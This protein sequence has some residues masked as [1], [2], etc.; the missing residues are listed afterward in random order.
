MKL[1][2]KNI[3][4][5]LL[6]AVAWISCNDDDNVKVGKQTVNPVRVKEIEGHNESWG[7][8]TLKLE[9]KNDKISTIER[10]DKNGRQKGELEITKEQGVMTY[11]LDDYVYKIDA[12]A[13]ADLDR[14]LALKYGVGNYSLEDSIPLVAKTVYEVALTFDEESMVTRQKISYFTP[15]KDFGV[16]ED[17]DNNYPLERVETYIYEYDEGGNVLNV[18]L[19]IDKYRPENAKDYVSRELYKYEYEYHGGKIVTNRIYRVNNHSEESWDLINER[20]Y[21]Y[22]G[23]GLM[24]V[25]GDG[26]SLERIYS[27]ARAFSLNLNGAV[28]SYTLNEYG[29][30]IKSDNGKGEVMNVTYEPGNGN[31]YHLYRLDREQEGFPVIK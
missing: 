17:F 29:F 3:G 23:N 22:S 31:F 18:R 10:F 6:F 19:F 30:L 28:T 24:S 26:Y 12:D 13:I 11:S 15:K 21:A 8:Y 27:D 16:G 25:K 9:Y 20:A 7:D 14:E 5:L 4:C 2:L 1:M